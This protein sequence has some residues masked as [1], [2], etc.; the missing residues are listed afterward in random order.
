MQRALPIVLIFLTL[1][2]SGCAGKQTQSEPDWI[3]GNSAD[4]PNAH[5]LTGRGQSENAAV[6]RDR[7]R[8]DLARI[9]QV[10]ISEQSEDSI[11]HSRQS[12]DGISLTTLEAETSRNIVSRTEHTLTDVEIAELWQH[13]KS[14]QFYAL[15]VL[16]RL[17]AGN[18]LRA[19]IQQL[20]KMVTKSIA[21]AKQQTELLAQIGAAGRAV[22][23]QVVRQ[24]LQRRL[25]V[26][27]S[28][29]T[30]VSDGQN[31]AALID[32][33]NSLLKRL[34]IGSSI[35]SDPLGGL[36]AVIEGALSHAGFR[37]ESLKPD[38]ELSAHLTLD[39]F[40][41]DRGWYWYRGTLLITLSEVSNN[42]NLGT[43]RW[44]VKV[45]AQ[46]PDVAARRVMGDLD[47]QL[48]NELRSVII[49]FAE[50]E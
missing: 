7:A 31:L 15:A 28:T 23:H 26:V 5:Y 43:H 45:A 1:A 6:A 37:N 36:D 13:P 12:S 27:D 8:A 40:R 49:G 3:N 48:K 18:S 10:N 29:G 34:R 9:F 46:L 39:D 2:I 33:R 25:R 14:K 30:G 35:T 22:E 44:N 41:D 20:D 16:D 50:P 32:D 19:E 11:K 21:Q 38:Y 42:R 17:K 4:Y 24:N 47:G